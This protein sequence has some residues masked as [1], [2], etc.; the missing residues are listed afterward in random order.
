M[1]SWSLVWTISVMVGAAN[2]A[3]TASEP[4][5]KLVHPAIVLRD[6]SG[7][8]VLAS[9]APIS[10]RNTCG[11]CHDYDFITDS[12]HF[13]QGHNEMDRSLLA[14]HGIASYNSSPG[15]FGKF[16]IIP[17][18]QL[19]HQGITSPDDFDLSTP[20]WLLKCGVCH[21]GGGISEFDMHGRKLGTV[22]ASEIAALDPDYFTR[23]PLTGAI[24]AWDWSKSGIA[25]ADCFIC[26]VP[27]A[28]R[29]ERK[30]RMAKG[31]F[32]WAGTATL[33]GTAVVEAL[34]D[35]SLRYRSSAFN[36]DGTVKPE[37]LD[38]R[39]PLLE[40]CAQCHGFTARNTT[41]IQPI[42]FGDIMRGTEKAGWIYN[43]ARISD[44]VK[45]EIVG[46]EALGFP[47]DV[48]AA[49]N[50]VCIDCH[51]STNNPGRMIHADAEKNLLYKP[52]QEDIAPYLKRP[53]HNFARGN[54]PP[55]TVN[56]T[57]HD[58]MRGCDEC[59][60]T[61]RTHAFLPYKEAHFRSLA[62]Q[63]CH[64]PEVHFWAY[65]SDEWGFLMD[66]GT[67]RI[68]FRGIEGDIVDP[69]SRVTGFKPAYIVTTSKQGDPEIRP[70]NLIT[71]VYWFDTGKQRPVFTW[72]VQK[73]LF[74]HRDE[75]GTWVH[76]PEVASAFDG[77]RDEILI[78][79]EAVYDTPEKVELV[80][81][82][83]AEHA[84]IAGAELRI[85]VVPWAM[86]HSTVGRD[87]AI[88]ECTT[89]HSGNSVLRQPMQLDDVLPQGV[90]VYF[91]GARR[92]VVR[93]TVDG[94]VFDNRELLSS[95]YIIGSS[96]VAWVE[97]VGWL[98]VA[99]A[100]LFAFVH[101]GL[102]VVLPLWNRLF[103]GRS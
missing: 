1:R 5:A 20:Q 31:D 18:R 11:P 96:R 8:N 58:T 24:T 41:I 70:T 49:K 92:S 75:D 36:P 71:G 100:F 28:S 82:L 103:G 17:N 48:H 30:E 83:L 14:A 74:D 12:L 98:A 15:M 37:A 93:W 2:G 78:H 50:L 25:E 16:S 45:P 60:D 90:P 99:A 69:D 35:G 61:T 91:G 79:E 9:K 33:A 51:F 59:H 40:N 87:Q 76:R 57:R 62:C 34:E 56:M 85:E 19:T 4:G 29:K 32:R 94:P 97:V 42:A 86:S 38:L 3:E 53:D 22:P 81:R 6:E 44:T 54:I 39:D 55:E 65:R 63:T 77:D 88:R 102:R 80:R 95:F 89:C 10:T 68:T 43:G 21:T 46:R 73:A 52:I 7:A 64:I 66:T 26:H 67:S 72:Q 84:G 23:D 13:Q 27:G 47:W 101:G